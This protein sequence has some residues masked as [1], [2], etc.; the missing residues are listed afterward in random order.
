MISYYIVYFVILAFVGYIYETLAMTAWGGKWESRGFLYGPII[1]IYGVGAL[2]GTLFF[3]YVVKDYTPQ[4]VFLAGFIGSV[5]LEYP[6]SVI[7]EKLFHAHWW[8]YSI[9]PFNING[10]VSLFSSMGFG[11][12]AMIIVY[13]INPVLLPFIESINK[14]VLDLLSY[15]FVMLIS[16]DST[17][18]VCVL[19]TFE[20]R[21]SNIQK[22]LDE[23]FSEVVSNINPNEISIKGALKHTKENIIDTNAKRISD[24]MSK[25]YHL[26][27]GRVTSFSKSNNEKIYF[28]KDSIKNYIDRKKNKD[29]R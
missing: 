5:I 18:T 8:D 27:I 21:V 16:I 2:L 20:D 25:I 17:L 24:S 15:I 10:R 19:T 3:E 13:L 26:A 6:T 12:A 1:P 28:I 22:Y 7:L 14:N 4:I 9:A 23:H 29:E 11:M